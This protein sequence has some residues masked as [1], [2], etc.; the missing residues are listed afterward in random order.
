MPWC[1]GRHDRSADS[2]P[3]GGHGEGCYLSATYP[4]P[5]RWFDRIELCPLFD[6]GLQQFWVQTRP[7][8][9]PVPVLSLSFEQC[10][11]ALSHT[12]RIV[13]ALNDHAR[14][15]KFTVGHQVCQPLEAVDDPRAG[16]VEGACRFLEPEPLITKGAIQFVSRRFW[17]IQRAAASTKALFPSTAALRK[18]CC[19]C[20]NTSARLWNRRTCSL[21]FSRSV[22]DWLLP[23]P[24]SNHFT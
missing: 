10:D 23:P 13:D 21:N 22:S 7:A 5:I 16:G 24:S 1:A 8:G 20:L 2:K 19:A 6:A 14:Q 4:L 3:A 15:V 12:H 18:C 9:G 17:P 11:C